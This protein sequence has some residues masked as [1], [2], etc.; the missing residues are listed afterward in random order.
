MSRTSCF[1]PEWGVAHFP[2]TPLMCIV[3]RVCSMAPPPT[4][5]FFKR[6]Q[7]CGAAGPTSVLRC[8][9]S[10]MHFISRRALPNTIVHLTP[11]TGDP[12]RI[13]NLSLSRTPLAY[14]DRKADYCRILT[15]LSQH[16]AQWSVG[17]VSIELANRIDGSGSRCTQ[18]VIGALSQQS[19]GRRVIEAA[20]E[21]CIADE[22]TGCDR[23]VPH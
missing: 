13:V 16:F 14:P 15:L 12:S 23:D 4:R 10:Q 20:H 1:A 8:T 18:G 17:M 3:S 22:R 7:S 11:Q 6:A 5:P 19:E 9:T 2:P 21:S